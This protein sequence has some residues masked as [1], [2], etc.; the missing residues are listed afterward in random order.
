MGAMNNK[1]KNQLQNKQQFE[2]V[3]PQTEQFQIKIIDMVK[4]LQKKCDQIANDVKIIR[5]Q[6]KP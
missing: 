2:K 5:T 6:M 3:S 4:K 1:N